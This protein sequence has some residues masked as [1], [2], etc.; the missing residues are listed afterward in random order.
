MPDDDD[1][2]AEMDRNRAEEQQ[3]QRDF[4][5][6]IFERKLKGEKR[7]SEL[8]IGHLGEAYDSDEGSSPATPP[9][10]ELCRTVNQR[11]RVCALPLVKH[12]GYAICRRLWPPKPA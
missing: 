10:A 11:F 8:R 12:G 5:K 7:L 2:F 1:P 9:I 3:K 6:L 4:T